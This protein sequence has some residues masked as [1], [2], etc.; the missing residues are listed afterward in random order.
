MKGYIIGALGGAFMAAVLVVRAGIGDPE[1]RYRDVV[2]HDTVLIRQEPDTVVR[3]RDRIV[4]VYPEAE[5]VATAPDA[6]QPDV[7]G[8]CTAAGWNPPG[9]PALTADTAADAPLRHPIP[10]ARLPPRL[11]IRSGTYD[12][13]SL[14]LF[15]VLSTGDLQRRDYD[16]RA[17]F[18]FRAVGDSVIVEGSRWDGV[19][20]VMKAAALVGGGYV[21]GEA[22]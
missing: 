17:P 22:F 20:A 16:V 8:F 19:W 11:L 14:A 15:G 1:P 5:Q 9:A 10:V 7:V 18:S 21:L 4:H 12:D 2:V 3:W 13:G 6:A